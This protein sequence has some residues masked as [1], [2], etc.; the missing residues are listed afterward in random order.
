MNGRENEMDTKETKWRE[1]EGDM[2][3]RLGITVWLQ[4]MTG[5]EKEMTSRLDV[6]GNQL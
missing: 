5:D 2:F 1:R 6:K 3:R 4:W